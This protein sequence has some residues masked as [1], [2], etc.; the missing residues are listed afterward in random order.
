MRRR[1]PLAYHPVI[2]QENYLPYLELSTLHA[3]LEV[4]AGRWHGRRQ[5]WCQLFH[6]WMTKLTI[7]NGYDEISEMFCQRVFNETSQAEEN[8]DGM[9]RGEREIKGRG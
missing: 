5:L 7:F 3:G 2:R 9:G 1:P 6:L 4:V 8:N